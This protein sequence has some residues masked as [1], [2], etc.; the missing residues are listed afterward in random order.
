MCEDK[1]LLLTERAGEWY[2]SKCKCVHLKKIEQMIKTSGLSE[3]DR[4]INILDFTPTPKTKEM[5]QVVQ[6]YLDD[7][8]QIYKSRVI[9]KGLSL[10]GYVG[11]GKTMLAQAVANRLLDKS[12]PVIFVVTPALIGELRVAQFTD[13]G[14]ALEER[15]DILSSVEVAIFD[16]VAKEKAS[17]WVQT[18]YFRIVDNRCRNRL[19]TI[20][21]S[22]H[23]LDG[24]SERLGDAVA[25]RIYAMTKGRQVW[26]EAKDYRLWG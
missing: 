6:Q 11:T 26:C 23:S 10:T 5:L 17:E 4:R 19:P 25:S 7:F 18:Q 15:I 1:G 2:A 20:F 13:G 9:T 8:P 22:N 24:I 14:H 16:D 12:I 21:T 3:D